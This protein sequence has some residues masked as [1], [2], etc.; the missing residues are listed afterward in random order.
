MKKMY[1]TAYELAVALEVSP[2]T[3]Y[4][5]VGRG[6]PY[7]EVKKKNTMVKRF[8]QEDVE[9]WVGDNLKPSFNYKHA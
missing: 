7:V 6:L 4:N 3:I 9:A 2:A 8:K 5:W 1:M